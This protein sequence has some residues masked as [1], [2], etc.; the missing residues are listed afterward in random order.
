MN[1]MQTKAYTEQFSLKNEPTL[2]ESSHD[3]LQLLC[4]H[5]PD[6][7]LKHNKE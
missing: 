3:N 4:Q 2:N 1:M 7:N 5:E 6:N